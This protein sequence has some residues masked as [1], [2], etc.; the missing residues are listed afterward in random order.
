ML[1]TAALAAAGSTTALA[2]VSRPDLTWSPA[3]AASSTVAVP[4]PRGPEDPA[5][6]F[7]P[8]GAS[9]GRLRA[10]V[11]RSGA[12]RP[13]AEH[14]TARPSRPGCQQVS[15]ELEEGA[16]VRRHAELCTGPAETPASP[17]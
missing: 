13:C 7:G 1:L 17:R 16:L 5:S 8:A 2:K 15:A 4:V 11:Q 14:F 9:A 6:E 12:A 10:L 3:C